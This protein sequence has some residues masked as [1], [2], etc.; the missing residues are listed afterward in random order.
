MYVHKTRDALWL[1]FMLRHSGTG[2]IEISNLSRT[3][4]DYISA[5]Y[6]II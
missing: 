5:L 4:T 2:S 1:L 3:C 6:S